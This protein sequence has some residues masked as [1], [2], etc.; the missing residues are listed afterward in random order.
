MAEKADAERGAAPVGSLPSALTDATLWDRLAAGHVAVFLDYDGTL[1]PIVPDPARA[2][3]PSVTRAVL[4]RLAARCPLAIVS[5]RDVRIVQEFVGVAAA[6]YAG[7]H[8]FEIIRLDGSVFRCTEA[9]R[10]LPALDRAEAELRVVLATVPGVIIERKRFAVAVH[11]RNAEA[12]AVPSV[13]AAVD[14]ALEG[15]PTLDRSAGKK[16]FELHP[17][18]A[19]DKGR[20]V[21]WLLEALEADAGNVVPLYIGDD[22]TDEDAFRALA[23]RG[24]TIVVAAGGRGSAAA[25]RL[26]DTEEVREFL[27]R[28]ADVLDRG[29]R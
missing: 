28:L 13:S 29:T 2:F 24:L 22:V 4:E 16:V 8:G 1:A 14:Q 11:Y 12:R 10:C 23:G 25:F 26:A 9:E 17:R 6:A 5:G 15:K 18:V 19:W 27:N 7:S 21:L 3:L 20:A